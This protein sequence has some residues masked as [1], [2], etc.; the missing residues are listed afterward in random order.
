MRSLKSKGLMRIV[1]VVMAIMVVSPMTMLAS[2]E[3][4]V[5]EAT[6]ADADQSGSMQTE[7]HPFNEGTTTNEDINE[8]PTWNLPML[9]G[10]LAAQAASHVGFVETRHSD[11]LEQPLLITGELEYRPPDILIRR[12]ISPRPET[13]IIQDKHVTIERPRQND[14]YLPL[15]AAPALEGLA[16]ALRGVL[17]GRQ[18]LLEQ[19]FALQLTGKAACWQLQLTPND[20]SVS[21][22]IAQLTIYGKHGELRSFDIVEPDGDRAVVLLQDLIDNAE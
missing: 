1:L 5:S 2:E 20:A 14:R 6:E 18:A 7:P 16:Q 15:S 9:M 12:I 11:L 22:E 4:V 19:A 21:E 13:F 8:Q 17:G 3:S 10:S